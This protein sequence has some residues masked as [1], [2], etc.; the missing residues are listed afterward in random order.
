MATATMAFLILM[1]LAL[2]VGWQ[3]RWS[4][5]GV[6]DLLDRIYR[7]GIRGRVVRDVAYGPLAREKLD[8]WV[9]EGPGPHP[10]VVFLHGGGWNTG[11]RQAY[12]FA[13]RALTE[14]G[15]MAVLPDYRLAP[16]NPFPAFI[17]DGAAAVAWVRAH[18]AVHGGDPERITLSGHSAG[19]HIS[20]MLALD[21]QWLE[22]AGAGAN[23]VKAFVGLSGPYDFLPF[24]SERTRQAFEGVVFP[25]TV[26]PISFVRPDAPPCLLI[27]G[28]ADTVV[29]PRN[30][31]SL[32][33]ELTRQ[34]ARAQVITYTGLNHAD[35][36]MALS[37]PF[38]GKADVLQDLTDFALGE[39][40]QKRAPNAPSQTA[41]GAASAAA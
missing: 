10:V 14:K 34:G 18:I 7:L 4:Q 19:A 26:Q 21:G 27:T 13:G 16:E 9:P 15:F 35:T 22:K 29:L 36:V 31:R 17:E 32:A 25:E 20:A 12:G 39:G 37:R 24:E 41:S 30:S 11:D 1:A 33:A 40:G 23:A 2:F 3:V 5:P 6:L 8:I 38:R 28:D